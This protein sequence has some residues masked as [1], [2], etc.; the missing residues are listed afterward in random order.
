MFALADYRGPGR[1]LV[2]AFKERGRRDLARVFGGLVAAAV[3]KLPGR[4]PGESGNWW[5]VPAPSRR[6]AVRRRGGSHLVGVA[7]ASG[8]RTV[9]AL[10]FTRG[11]TDSVGLDAAARRANLAGRVRL[12][13]GGLPPPDAPVVLLDDVV[14]TGATA[15]ACVAVLRAGGYRVAAVLAL[16]AARRTHPH[17]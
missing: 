7:R 1:E 5:L 6:A 11:V 13:R 15:S 2:L 17:G 4:Y 12:V 14:T 16:T 3:P 8:L 9:S 10:A